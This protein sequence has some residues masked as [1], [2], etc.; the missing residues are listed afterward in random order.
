MRLPTAHR[1]SES[2]FRAEQNKCRLLGFGTLYGT[3]YIGNTLCLG[4]ESSRRFSTVIGKK[5][6]E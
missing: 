2:N 1:V 5:Q 3:L 6:A 4:M